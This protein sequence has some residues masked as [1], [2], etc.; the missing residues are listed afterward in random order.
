MVFIVQLLTKYIQNGVDCGPWAISVMCLLLMEGCSYTQKGGN[1]LVSPAVSAECGHVIRERV[2]ESLVSHLTEC[3]RWFQLLP[4]LDGGFVEEEVHTIMATGL[5]EYHNVQ[6]MAAV[7][8][9]KGATCK[10]CHPK[11]AGKAPMDET[12][13][14]TEVEHDGNLDTSED[15]EDDEDH[16]DDEAMGILGA[17]KLRFPHLKRAG[18]KIRGRESRPTK[19]VKNIQMIP[20]VPKRFQVVQRNRCLD[21]DDYFHGPVMEDICRFN[22]DREGWQPGHIY[23]KHKPTFRSSGELFIDWGYRILPEFSQMFA[24]SKPQKFSEHCFPEVS[25]GHDIGLRSAE[26]VDQHVVGMKDM[27]ELVNQDPALLVDVFVKGILAGE[28]GEKL[29]LKLDANRDDC[30]ESLW[31]QIK[32]KTSVDIDSIIAVMHK[33][34]LSADVEISVLPTGGN[35]PPLTKSNHTWVHLLQP[36]S[37]DDRDLGRREE[38]FETSH[39]PSTIPHM[40]FGKVDKLFDVIIMFPRMKHKNPLTGQS[41]TLIPWEIQNQFLV[42]V[43]HPAMAFASDEACHL[44][45]DYDIETWRWKSTTMYGFKKTVVMQHEQLSTLQDV[46]KDTIA[47]DPELAH[48]GSFFFVMEAKGIKLRTMTMD[49]DVNVLEV[50]YEKFSCVNFDQLSKREN[51]QVLIDLGLGYH[52]VALNSHGEEDSEPKFVCLW[53]LEKLDQIYGQAGFNKGTSHNANTMRWF[54][55]RQS[56]MRADRAPLVHLCFRSSYGLYYE[57]FRKVRG[58]EIPLCDDWDAYYTNKD[59]FSSLDSYQR[60]M[61]EATGKSLG[62]RDELR[63]SLAAVS[64]LLGDLPQL[65]RPPCFCISNNI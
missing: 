6:G 20:L 2:L 10:K 62:V 40:H 55:G 16:E 65:V 61:E 54:G 45:V 27:V 39:S 34:T 32:I 11:T 19:V 24:T 12:V 9:K 44:Y 50:L 49:R 13:D 35:K 37:Q 48:F 14:D 29:F 3:Y 64:E 26:A 52:P 43:L 4:N 28:G 18:L 1:S 36:Q 5:G 15:D 17:F 25:G 53:D 23:G 51:G 31:H 41:A 30:L 58:G 60:I 38:W 21:Y 33:L 47:Q 46:M 22:T 63:G 42:E 8:A 57:P 56:Q 59:F 7:L